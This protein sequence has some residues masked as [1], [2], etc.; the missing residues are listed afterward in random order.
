[1]TAHA[2]R[3]A[4]VTDSEL[5]R[6]ALMALV[7]GSQNSIAVSIDVS[8]GSQPLVDYL[9]QH[10][11]EHLDMWLLDISAQHDQSILHI[12]CDGSDKPI[13]VN[14]E[15]PTA[16]HMQSYQLWQKRLLEKVAGLSI[17]NNGTDN[18]GLAPAVQV[19]VLAASLGGP[20]MVKRFLSS[21]PKGLPIAF[22]YVQHIEAEFDNYLAGGMGA[23]QGYPLRLINR[24]QNLRAGE[25]LVV[26]ADAQLR[27]L[28]F[29]G[30]IKTAI[31]WQGP[32]QPSIDQVVAELGKEYRKKLG[33]IIFSGTCN[34]GEI[35]CR[36]VKACGGKVWAQSPATCVSAAMPEAAM[37]TGCV[38]FQGSPE[39][40]AM[41][42]AHIMAQPIA[43]QEV[44]R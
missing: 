28:P 39:E 40:L 42:L 44:R 20:A 7:G 21:L 23:E 32:Y 25:T 22:V 35:G 31:P 2:R 34:D 30:V 29:G 17:E 14:D 36:V 19:W 37:S 8:L 12:V 43:Q 9:Q 15:L 38:S 18:V 33:V 10:H 5:G 6:Q 13:L 41:Q 16:Q 27:F 4:L 26:P 11:D 3:V 24:E 1:M